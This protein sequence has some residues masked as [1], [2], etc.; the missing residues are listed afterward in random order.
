MSEINTPKSELLQIADSVAR[1]TLIEPHL[2]VEAME[3]SLAKAA[4]LKYGS[5]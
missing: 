1:E 4:K 5:E 2:V 3:D